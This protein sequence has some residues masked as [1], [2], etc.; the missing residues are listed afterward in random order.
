LEGEILR[1]I[2]I[3]EQKREAGTQTTGRIKLDR[4]YLWEEAREKKARDGNK[5][6]RMNAVKSIR[7]ADVGEIGHVTAGQG[8]GEARGSEM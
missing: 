5:R 6:R 1:W 8:N 4:A 2:Y 3:R 7:R